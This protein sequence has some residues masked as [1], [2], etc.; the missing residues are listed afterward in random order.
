LKIYDKTVLIFYYDIL[1]IVLIR[2]EMRTIKYFLFAL[3]VLTI[4]S[5]RI[6]FYVDHEVEQPL[7]FVEISAIVKASGDSLN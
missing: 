1:I 4:S 7:D 2:I 3:F 5:T 6:T